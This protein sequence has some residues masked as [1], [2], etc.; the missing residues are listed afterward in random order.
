MLE[1]LPRRSKCTRR[2]ARCAK[3][4]R[5]RHFGSG[6][7]DVFAGSISKPISVTAVMTL[8]DQGNFTDDRVKKFLPAFMVM[9]G[10]RCPFAIC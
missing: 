5:L 3:T 2:V 1:R 7:D 4:S 8:F 6:L 9:G 10:T